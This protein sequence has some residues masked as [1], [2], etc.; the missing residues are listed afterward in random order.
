MLR[1]SQMDVSVNRRK[2]QRLSAER[3]KCVV[4][5]KTHKKEFGSIFY[6]LF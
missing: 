4:A 2:S 5:V 1:L 6:F 3:A